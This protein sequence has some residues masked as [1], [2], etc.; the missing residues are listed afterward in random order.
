MHRS[1]FQFSE[2]SDLLK[3]N[4]STYKSILLIELDVYS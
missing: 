4:L 2:L 3:V 1:E